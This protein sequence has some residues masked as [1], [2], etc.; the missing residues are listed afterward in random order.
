MLK[1]I[2]VLF[3][4]MKEGSKLVSKGFQ[5]VSIAMDKLDKVL[6]VKLEEAEKKE[7][8]ARKRHEEFER[9]AAK[10]GGFETVEDWRQ[11]MDDETE[12]FFK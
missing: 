11:C 4:S 3:K 8:E 9:N 10:E 6:D 5:E 7:E 2:A 12:E 1:I